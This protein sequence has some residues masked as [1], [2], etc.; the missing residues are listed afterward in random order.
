MQQTSI[1]SE[2]RLLILDR[3]AANASDPNVIGTV[4]HEFVG[5]R[6][7][8]QYHIVATHNTLAF[9]TGRVSGPEAFVTIDGLPFAFRTIG[10]NGR[11]TLPTLAG[12]SFAMRFHGLD[13]RSLGTANGQAPATGTLDIGDPLGATATPLTVHATPDRR[14]VVDI[15]ATLVFHFSEPVDT[16]TLVGA[17]VVTDA[18]GSRVFGRTVLSADGL[19]ATFTPTRRWRF[20]TTYRYGL[21]LTL[22]A[23]SGAALAASFSGEFTTFRPAVAGTLALPNVHDVA[24][25]SHVAVVGSDSGLH[26]VDVSSAR[27]PQS[28]AAVPI[29]GG[30]NA[31]A[32][33]PSTPLIDRNGATHQGPLAVVGVGSSST[34]SALQ[35]FD[36]STASPTLIGSTHVTAAPGQAPPAGVPTFSGTPRALVTTTDARAI[37]AIESVGVSSVHIG[38]AIPIDAA[39]PTR[40]LGPRYPSGAES[41]HDV[42]LIGNKLLVAGA[43]G[44]TI[45]ESTTLQRL[46]GV[47][48][49]GTA[50][51][52]A[53]LSMFGVDVD[54]SGHIAPDTEVFDLAVVANGADGSVQFYRLPAT[55]DP[56]LLS[57]VRFTGL[58]TT[59]VRLDAAER[60]AYVGLAGRGAAVVDLD[61][62]ASVQP[63]DLD[64]NG[65]D[66]RILGTIDTGGAASRL[67][68]DMARGLG[69]LADGARGLTVLQLLPPRTRFVTLKRDPVRVVS[70]DET[71]ILDSESAYLTDDRLQIVVDASVPSQEPLTLALEHESPSP[72]LRFATGAVAAPMT[73]GVNT[74]DLDVTGHGLSSATV[75]RLSVRTSSGVELAQTTVRFLL[76]EVRT[77]GLRV[78]KLG[79]P[80]VALTEQA[81]TT[82]LGVAGFFDDGLILNLTRST[83]GTTYRAAVPA[84]ATVDASGLVSGHAGGTA[85]ILAVNAGVEGSLS[86]QVAKPVVLL[87]LEAG[88]SHVTLR[89]IG[90]EVTFPLVALFSD[91]TLVTDLA[92]LPFLSFATTDA[93]VVAASAGGTL[94]AIGPGIARVSATSGSLQ[95]SIDVA[96]DPRTPTSISGISIRPP[97]EPL[98]M[99]QAPLYG[100][101]TIAGSGSL[102]G[103]AITIAISAG[104]ASQSTTATS[105][106]DGAARFQLDGVSA[107]QVTAIASVVD[108]AS[109]LTR[110]ATA[111]FMLVPPTLDAEPNDAPS[112]P[113]TLGTGRT[114][115]GHVGGPGDP[116]DSYRFDPGL[117]GSLELTLTASSANV[118]LV[119][120]DAA[121]LELARLTGSGVLRI[122]L[123][124]GA[125][126]ISVESAGGASSY[127]LTTRFVQAEVSV[128]AVT[129]SAGAA[130]TLVTIAGS[131]FSTRLS[132]NQVFFADIAADIVA[133]TPTQLQV[134]VPANAVDGLL[135][136]ISGDRRI[137]GPSF[138]TGLGGPRPVAF[139]Q[140]HDPTAVR[141]DPISGDP[142]DLT[143]LFVTAAAALRRSD[144]EAIAQRHGGHV[145]GYVPLTNWYVLQFPQNSTLDGLATLRLAIAVEPGV[146]SVAL[147]RH[148]QSTA[149]DTID[150]LDRSTVFEGTT[151]ARRTA[152]DRIRLEEA[153]RLARRTRPFDDRNRLK[154]VRVAVIDTGFDPSVPAEFL[155][156]GQRTAEYLEINPSTGQYRG[157]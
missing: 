129:P 41:A 131:G 106:I 14:S 132:E 19:T 150:V 147:S 16:R 119:I 18:A 2:A 140:P 97:L 156:Q 152:M 26:T 78:L 117:A 112:A 64:R 138:S 36:V 27:S 86:I 115:I 13:G 43:A 25:S 146:R 88:S 83:T 70:G 92:A 151:V 66:D 4:G 67:T 108:P 29:A 1:G 74:F 101:A 60:L 71:V 35:T 121:G 104:A 8:G 48:T 65:T 143:R 105:G 28:I 57:V 10:P 111:T 9:V 11:F 154:N 75:V 50:Q 149:V 84:V 125:A 39:T 21:S 5:V 38:Q 23:R 116:R 37:A 52:V 33:V 137:V 58:T 7:S 72:V 34:S 103:H 15:N 47:S 141:R 79:P 53:A 20:G 153:V 123:P 139:S 76:P 107:G 142:V 56:L 94:R 135:E 157:D 93:T 109:G 91:R 85:S 81:A 62:P 118:V 110:T 87:A 54:G 144:V 31:V 73:E 114:S 68:L 51:G 3:L 61:G 95:A 77:A 113:S 80:N 24:V 127:R 46:S 30:V 134:Q 90:A 69:Y 148:F 55:G 120:R 59:S 130:G 122:D 126:S 124:A 133:A 63:L 82:Q 45:L 22:V 17:L 102:D 6:T 42:A 96:V 89:S 98:L 145:V 12:Q 32:F 155:W 100:E 99:D 44:L 136:I 49:T 128:Q 40:G